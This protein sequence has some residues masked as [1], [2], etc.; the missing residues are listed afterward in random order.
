MKPIWVSDFISVKNHYQCLNSSFDDDCPTMESVRQYNSIS[1][2][3][4]I[5]PPPPLNSTFATPAVIADKQLP[6]CLTP[7]QHQQLLGG[8][9]MQG[10]A[11]CNTSI[12]KE[13]QWEK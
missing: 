11:P 5:L 10:E 7:L 3:T 2:P 12:C 9:M 4:T 8:K 1:S 6:G 13:I